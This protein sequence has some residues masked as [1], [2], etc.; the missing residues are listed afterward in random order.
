MAA[1]GGFRR[2]RCFTDVERDSIE[3]IRL[4]VAEDHQAMREKV[5]GTLK[6]EYTIVDAVGDGEEMLNAE[7]II[8]PDVVVL[9]IS[10]PVVNGIEAAT[11]LRQRHSKAK[12]VFLTVHDEPEYVEAALAIGAHGYVIKSR[13]ASDLCLA[14][15][16]AMAG[17]RFVSPTISMNISEDTVLGTV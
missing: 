16:E 5:V 6:D 7:S 11:R 8:N 13:L 4:L 14:V 17:R 1:S 2:G 10:M 15:R 3:M 12:I 9:D